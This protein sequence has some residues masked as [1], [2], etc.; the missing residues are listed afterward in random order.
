MMLAQQWQVRGGNR[1]L[2]AF[3]HTVEKHRER[4]FKNDILIAMSMAVE[5]LLALCLTKS[6]INKTV[7]QSKYV[8]VQIDYFPIGNIT[9]G[10]IL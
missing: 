6:N 9:E 5:K 3:Q 7:N 10:W 8:L 4:V 1:P 2:S